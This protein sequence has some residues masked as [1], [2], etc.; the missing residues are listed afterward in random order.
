MDQ[1]GDCDGDG[2]FV[3]VKS[4]SKTSTPSSACN[5]VN[6]QWVIMNKRDGKSKSLP[7]GMIF[8]GRED[9]DLILNSATVDKRHAVI[10]Y[11]KANEQFHVKDLNSSY[12]VSCTSKTSKF[13]L[14]LNQFKIISFSLKLTYLNQLT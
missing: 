1:I 10:F 2:N 6:F 12:G 5:S 3:T 13:I 4:V 11:N 9:C 7:H 14:L 8:V